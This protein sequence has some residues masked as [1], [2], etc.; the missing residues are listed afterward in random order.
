[1]GETRPVKSGDGPRRSS[2]RNAAFPAVGSRR[3][4]PEGAALERLS[5][6]FEVPIERL[7]YFRRLRHGYEEI[8]P[9]L[10]VA[11]EA[12]VEA[13]RVLKSRMAGDTWKQI[14]ESF[15]IDLKPLNEEVIEVLK[16]LRKNLSKE[17]LTERPANH[18]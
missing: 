7:Q 14:A 12:Q 4:D 10:I 1:M 2:K 6:R 11:R 8:V 9:A 17:A 3:T 18:K 13:G 5:L 15:S 16:P